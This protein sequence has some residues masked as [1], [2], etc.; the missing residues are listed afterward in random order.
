MSAPA[1][2]AQFVAVVGACTYS[3]NICRIVR[4]LGPFGSWQEAVDAGHVE[5]KRHRVHTDS[6]EHSIEF[7]VSKLEAK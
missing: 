1:N 5:T 2:A 7:E 6:E 4:V 3:L